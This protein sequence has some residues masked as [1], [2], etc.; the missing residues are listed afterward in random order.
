MRAV[1]SALDVATLVSDEE[2]FPMCFL[3][4]QSCGCPVVGMDTSGVRSTFARGRSGL[5]VAQDDVDGMVDALSQLIADEVRRKEMGQ[6]GRQWVS[7]NLSLEHMIDEY[8][9]VLTNAAA[10]KRHYGLPACS[11]AGDRHE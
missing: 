9:R 6:Y 1:Y 5:L 2:S 10:G 4:A 8:E 7:A 11:S 3:E